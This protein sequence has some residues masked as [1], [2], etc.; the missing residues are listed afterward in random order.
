M[1]KLFGAAAS[2]VDAAVW[3][4][5]EDDENAQEL[6]QGAWHRILDKLPRLAHDGNVVGWCVIVARNHCKSVLR[7]RAM[8]PEL[9]DLEEMDEVAGESQM[10]PDLVVDRS[11]A[12]SAVRASVTALPE[13]ERKAVTLRFLKEATWAET[14]GELG[15]AIPVAR[16]LVRQGLRVLGGEEC[17]GEAYVTLFG[18]VASQV[19]DDLETSS[20]PPVLAFLRSAAHR[21]EARSAVTSRADVFGA[22]VFA[23]SGSQLKDLLSTHLESP[24][25]VD[26]GTAL[27]KEGSATRSRTLRWNRVYADKDLLLSAIVQA[28]VAK[29]VKS[30]ADRIERRADPRACKIMTVI[31]DRVCAPYKVASL[32]DDLHITARTLGRRCAAMHIPSPKMLI[33][34]GRVFVTESMIDW[35]S[36]PA[37]AVAGL[38]GFSDASSYRRLAKNV[39]GVPYRSVRDRGGGHYVATVIAETLRTDAWDGR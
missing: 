7:G 30:L 19:Q 8:E 15:V 1:E 36:R 4:F 32:S 26:S 18:K 16:A 33:S 13:P 38:L 20:P 12:R 27:E 28:I 21:R 3:R 39:L 11:A 10:P 25:L 29:P 31:L 5:A 35:S 22:V 23:E 9:M 2:A 24:V 37:Q 17:L 34:L 14:A 6:A